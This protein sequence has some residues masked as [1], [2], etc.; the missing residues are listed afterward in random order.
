MEAFIDTLAD[1]DTED[2]GKLATSSPTKLKTIDKEEQ[3]ERLINTTIS[4]TTIPSLGESLVVGNRWAIAGSCTNLSGDWELLVTDN[5]RR[6]YDK[7]LESLGQ[8]RLVR[9]VALGIVAQTT[10]KIVQTDQG[11]SLLVVG[12]NIRGTWSRTL[13]ASGTDLDH[14]EFI[15]QLVPITSAD[16][17]LVEAESWWEDNGTIH[18]SWM[19]GVTKYGGG[20]FESRRYLE[21]DGQVYVCESTFH[22]TDTRKQPNK[23]TWRFRRQQAIS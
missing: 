12:R 8:P 16:S 7:Y 9:S 23:I 11:R 21:D 18:V 15:P 14:D 17:E 4:Q 10:E 5:F 13:V 2:V 3:E 6:Q 19:T 1:D 22:P 20:S